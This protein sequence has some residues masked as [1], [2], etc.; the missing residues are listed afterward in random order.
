M[1]ITKRVNPRFIYELREDETSDRYA[2]SYSDSV[3]LEF[4]G[5]FLSREEIE[6]LIKDLGLIINRGVTL[7][8]I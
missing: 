6:T 1:E 5:A 8:E 7:E 4:V 2:I 3:S